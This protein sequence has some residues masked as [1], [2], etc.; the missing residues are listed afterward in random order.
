VRGRGSRRERVQRVSEKGEKEERGKGD[1]C[2][3]FFPFEIKILIKFKWLFLK[4]EKK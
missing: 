1:R 2:G 3:G 4:G